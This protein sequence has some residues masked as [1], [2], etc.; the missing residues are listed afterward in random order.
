MFIPIYLVVII[1]RDNTRRDMIFRA[2]RPFSD[3]HIALKTGVFIIQSKC[4][5]SL[6]KEQVREVLHRKEQF[7]I[8]PIQD[9]WDALTD[10]DTID[11]IEGL[12]QWARVAA[13]E[14]ASSTLAAS[15]RPTPPST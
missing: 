9:G 4:Q 8:F 12:M 7:F 13:R 11:A 14:N 2:L 3:R 10:S 5:P 15:S 6:I 1:A